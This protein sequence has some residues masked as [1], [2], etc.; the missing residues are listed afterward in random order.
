MLMQPILTDAVAMASGSQRAGGVPTPPSYWGLLLAN[1]RDTVLGQWRPFSPAL[2]QLALP[3]GS[4]KKRTRHEVI[5]C[6]RR[7]SEKE[8]HG[9]IVFALLRI[10]FS[11]QFP[12]LIANFSSF[13]PKPFYFR[14][15]PPPPQGLVL[16][17]TATDGPKRNTHACF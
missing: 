7:E 6:L 8:R 13:S 3:Q 4:K 16:R 1:A 14:F 5:T 15:V 9:S 12:L 2:S 10:I 17:E 11:L